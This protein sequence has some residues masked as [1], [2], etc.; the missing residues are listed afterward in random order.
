M[1]AAVELPKINERRSLEL[2]PLSR[3]PAFRAHGMLRTVPFTPYQSE[4]HP[5]DADRNLLFEKSWFVL[6]FDA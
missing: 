4:R 3:K 2:H 5:R 6:E 1:M